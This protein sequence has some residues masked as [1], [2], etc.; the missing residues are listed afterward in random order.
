MIPVGLIGNSPESNR[1]L[2]VHTGIAQARTLLRAA[3]H[4]QGFPADLAYAT[5]TVFDGVPL[6]SLA[7][8]IQHDLA[9]AGIHI[10]LSPQPEPELLSAYRAGSLQMVLTGWGMDY[11]DPSDFAGPFSPGGGPAS[12]LSYAGDPVLRSLVAQADSTSNV[13]RRAALYERIQAIWLQD[14]PWIGLVQPRE[15]IVLKRNL[16]GYVFSPLYDSDF[17]NL[18]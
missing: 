16:Q 10:R 4:P 5:S 1:R 2:L 9:V 3:G 15:V 17:R 18:Q 13:S 7:I 14:S 6:D 12:H 8:K 11:P